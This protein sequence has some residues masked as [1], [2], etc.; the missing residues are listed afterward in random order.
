MINTPASSEKSLGKSFR[1]FFAIFGAIVLPVCIYSERSLVAKLMS[2]SSLNWIY[3]FFITLLVPILFCVVVGT[4]YTLWWRF[5]WLKPGHVNVPRLLLAV[6]CASYIAYSA[7]VVAT[8]EQ[9]YF[10]R[11]KSELDQQV[12]LIKQGSKIDQFDNLE[13]WIPD[14][15]QAIVFSYSSKDPIFLSSYGYVYAE[16][17]SDLDDVYMCSESSW[18]Y[19][20][21]GHVYAPLSTNWYLCYRTDDWN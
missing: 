7:P 2:F 20:L 3:A 15:S 13:V 9:L 10:E 12:E 16:A 6:L 5:G 18:R 21:G 11:H 8:P 1:I 19:G 14:K 17:Y 4:I